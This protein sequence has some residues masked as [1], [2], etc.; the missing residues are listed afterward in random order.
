MAQSIIPTLLDSDDED[1]K[2]WKQNLKAHQLEEQARVLCDPLSKIRGLQV[3]TPQGSMCAMVKVAM[4]DFDLLDDL[5]FLTMLLHE[6]NVFVLPGSAF[7]APHMIRV[8][9]CS[10]NSMLEEAVGRISAFCQRHW[11]NKERNVENH[12]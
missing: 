3:I 6:E 5:D 8:V 10:H 12:L 4:K 1:L 7:G 2:H 11:I 9:F